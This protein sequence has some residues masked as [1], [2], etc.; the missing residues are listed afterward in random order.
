[1]D[2]MV[3]YSMPLLTQEDINQI[4]DYYYW[5]GYREWYPFPET[6]R[7]ILMTNYGPD[8]PV[9]DWTEQDIYEG[10]RKIIIEFFS[11]QDKI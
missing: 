1:M 2:W 7:T 10:S 5:T 11:N 8:N 3:V 6:L 9:Q 4:E